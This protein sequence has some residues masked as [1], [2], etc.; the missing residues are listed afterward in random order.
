M[1]GAVLAVQ[2]ARS[3]ASIANWLALTGVDVTFV[4]NE[5]GFT[6]AAASD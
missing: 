2:D 5:A 1:L 6:L 3:I 4:A